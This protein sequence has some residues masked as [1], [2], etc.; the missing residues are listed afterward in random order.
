MEKRPIVIFKGGEGSKGGKIIGHTRSGKP[1]YA[2]H[3][4]P[5]HES[6]SED[7]HRDALRH[8]QFERGES[9]A[10]WDLANRNQKATEPHRQKIIAHD[11]AI[12]H[13]HGKAESIRLKKGDTVAGQL[14]HDVSKGAGEGS[15]GGHVIGHT[16]SGKPIYAPTPKNEGK[17][18]ASVH[19]QSKKASALK[20]LSPEDHGDMIDAHMAESNKHQSLAKDAPAD[21]DKF[22]FHRAM[23][24]AHYSS[25]S[26]HHIALHG[27]RKLG[28]RPSRVKD[29]H[30]D[31]KAQARRDAKKDGERKIVSF[32][33]QLAMA[34]SIGL[35]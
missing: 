11:N 28:E 34:R 31:L 6:F 12:Q 7:D 24:D 26:N 17:S 21:S 20:S 22:W 10:K 4:H 27:S 3:N 18:G 19:E 9:R 14:G 23:S 13:H 32:E 2:N 8:H 29:E 16:K 5:S 30:H 35:T 25:A 33:D 15:R 1:I